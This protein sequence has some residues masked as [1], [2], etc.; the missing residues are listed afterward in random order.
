VAKTGP[1]TIWGISTR[2]VD[3]EGKSA[4]LIE[5]RG[6]ARRRAGTRVERELGEEIDEEL[7]LQQSL[8]GTTPR[9]LGKYETSRLASLGIYQ[10]TLREK[11]RRANCGRPT[12]INYVWKRIGCVYFGDTMAKREYN[13]S[14][15]NGDPS[16]EKKG[17]WGE[18]RGTHGLMTRRLAPT[19]P[20]D[21]QVG[22]HHF[23]ESLIAPRR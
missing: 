6:L 15:R 1:K 23:V 7:I 11:F 21:V 14:R 19:P 16:W 12:L 9:D 20:N 5:N 22:Y 3:R 10:R 2:R 13:V 4:H 18:G 8:E 17:G